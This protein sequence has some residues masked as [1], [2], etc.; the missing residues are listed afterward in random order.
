[1]LKQKTVQNS[2]SLS[3]IGLHT[4][5]KSTITIQPAP[6]NYG[7]RFI[8]TDLDGQPEVL[9]DVDNVM[10]AARGTSIGIGNAVIH[11]IE[12]LMAAFASLYVS[13]A[14]ILVDAEELPLMDGSAKP[15][16]DLLETLGI[17]EQSAG[18]EFI[19]IDEPMYLFDDGDVALSVFPAKEFHITLMIDF[20]DPA[21]GA[22]HTTMFNFD[23]FK[24]DFS[25]ART[26]CFLSEIQEL[27]EA[28][29][30]KGGSLD[31]AVVVQDRDVTEEDTKYI[32]KLFNHNKKVVAGTNGFLNNTQLRY[33][34]ELCRHKALDLVGDL[35]LLGKPIKGHILGARTG[36][37]ANHQLAKKIRKNFIK[38]SE[39]K[40]SEETV[41]G[42]EE[43]LKILPHRYPFLFIDGVE[44]I[45]PG[46]T[47]TAYKNVSFNDNFFQGHFPGNPIMPG[48][49]Q[50][51]AMAQASGIM[52]LYGD[53]D[54]QGKTML[55]MGVNKV[56]FRGQVRPGDKLVMEVKMIKQRR[57]T[58]ICEG[59]AYVN[60]KLV[61]EAELMSM[62]GQA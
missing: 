29:L 20:N 24:E 55:F 58:I 11:T 16:I 18:Q 3:G 47:I 38:R 10:G 50:V 9:A 62:V 41:I 44:A 51:E 8:R 33:D 21:I 13:N 23:T 14:K 26:F 15:F 54:A 2:G 35:Y 49:L 45:E 27:R 40:M 34:N 4:G 53:E 7:I 6:E 28:G 39:D 46:Q 43:I 17:E 12:H 31:S 56:K 60:G 61:C 32:E 25:S 57:S 19:E 30:I 22:Q 5:A 37:A 36:H 42:Y 48:V 1:M 52:A 59:K